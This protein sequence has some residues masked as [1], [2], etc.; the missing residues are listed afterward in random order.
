MGRKPQFNAAKFHLTESRESRIV[1][2]TLRNY[3]MSIF[4]LFSPAGA[5]RLA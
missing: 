5:A 3:G 2:H 1:R 4:G